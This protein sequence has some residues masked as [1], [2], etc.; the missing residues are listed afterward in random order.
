MTQWMTHKM[1]LGLNREGRLRY[2]W[3]PRDRSVPHL[4]PMTEPTRALR[5]LQLALASRDKKRRDEAI[6]RYQQLLRN[7]RGR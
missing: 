1:L 7:A 2:Q 5:D 3:R 6:K 4:S